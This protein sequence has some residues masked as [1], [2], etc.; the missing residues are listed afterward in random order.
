MQIEKLDSVCAENIFLYEYVLHFISPIESLYPNLSKW[1]EEVFVPGLIRRERSCLLAIENRELIGC[2]LLKK[3]AEEKKISTLFVRP[4]YRKKGI[5]KTLLS[6]ALN[7]LRTG[8]SLSVS[9]ENLSC[10][11]PLLQEFNFSLSEVKEGFYR[12]GKKEY[13]FRQGENRIVSKKRKTKTTER[14]KTQE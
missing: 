8:A 1:Y 9:E 2:V 11:K 14:V 4:D 3:N 6:M 13:F 12:K 10:M 5:G 7:D